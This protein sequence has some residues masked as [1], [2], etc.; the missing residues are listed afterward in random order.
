MNRWCWQCAELV[1]SGEGYKV[2]PN[3]GNETSP[4][5]NAIV[6]GYTGDE[7]W[8]RESVARMAELLDQPLAKVTDTLLEGGWVRDFERQ[9]FRLV[10]PG[11]WNQTASNAKRN[12]V[13]RILAEWD[14]VL[15]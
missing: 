11:R 10:N 7:F 4:E 9:G 1:T 8:S 15:A 14:Q 2:C 12:K 13:D 5:Y 6:T 3:C